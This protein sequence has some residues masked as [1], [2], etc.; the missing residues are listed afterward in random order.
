MISIRNVSV[1]YQYTAVGIDDK[2]RTGRLLYLDVS[3]P[4]LE[5]I[6]SSVQWLMGP[7]TLETKRPGREADHSLKTLKYMTNILDAHYR[8]GNGSSTLYVLKI[9]LIAKSIMFSLFYNGSHC[10]EDEENYINRHLIIHTI[11]P[12]R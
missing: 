10:Q 3:R 12:C 2:A 11:Y 4:A 5:P 8:Y 7:H 1:T 9:A 6:Q